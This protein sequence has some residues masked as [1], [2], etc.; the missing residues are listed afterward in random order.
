MM[1]NNQNKKINWYW[2]IR[3]YVIVA[4]IVFI[5]T[6]LY[7]AFMIY[8]D[9]D[10]YNRITTT[11]VYQIKATA[12]EKVYNK[13]FSN[14]ERYQ[15][16]ISKIYNSSSNEYAFELDPF[17]GD[18]IDDLSAKLLKEK[19]ADSI[20]VSKEMYDRIVDYTNEDS[21]DF[22]TYS[23]KE[24]LRPYHGHV[25]I[26]HT[27]TFL[28]TL[29]NSQFYWEHK[30]ELSGITLVLSTV[31]MLMAYTV[32]VQYE[33]KYGILDQLKEGLNDYYS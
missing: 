17:K 8:K 15:V 12:T 22:V 1:E 16:V 28:G 18:Q 20:A 3:T 6:S 4:V 24:G 14:K 32:K 26:R 5:V 2:V 33:K 25:D 27:P 29:L 9:K 7:M 31:L 13:S 11:R 10:P 23:P 19:Q 21:K 30:L